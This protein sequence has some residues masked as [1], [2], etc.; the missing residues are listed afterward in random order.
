MAKVTQ[1]QAEKEVNEWLDYKKISQSKKASKKDNVDTLVAA[2]VDGDIIFTPEHTIKQILKFPLSVDKDAV[3][4]LEYK[5]R[6]STAQMQAA[7]KGA[8][9]TEAYGMIASLVGVLTGEMT[10]SIGAMDSEDFSIA[11]AIASFFLP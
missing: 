2:V 6:L 8:K 4:E 5:A 10:P 7:F 11:Q 3:K 9:M 1:E